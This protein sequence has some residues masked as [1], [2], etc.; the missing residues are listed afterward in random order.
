MQYSCYALSEGDYMS[1][2]VVRMNLYRRC[3]VQGV[4]EAAGCVW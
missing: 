4:G 1:L 3:V 2:Y